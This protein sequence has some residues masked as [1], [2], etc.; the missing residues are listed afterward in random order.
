MGLYVHSIG[1]LPTGAERGYYIYLLDYG[2]EEAFGEAV[3][4]NLPRMA[5]VASRSD[6]VVIYGPRGLHFEDEVLSWHRVNGERS[7]EILPA[8]LVTTRH[9]ATFREELGGKAKASDKDSLLLIPLKKACQ[10]PEEVVNMIQRV[11]ADI[12]DKKE[13]SN[14]RVIKEMHKGVGRAIVDA[15]VLEPNFSGVGFNFKKLFGIG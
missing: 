8:L 14:F 5:D 3:R 12:R 10:S 15:V 4:K 1:E 11:F 13:L 6:A 9:P 7:E 2:W